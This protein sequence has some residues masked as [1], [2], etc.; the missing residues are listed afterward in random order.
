VLEVGCQP[1]SANVGIMTYVQ[2]RL[3]SV[4]RDVGKGEEASI[5]ASELAARS[6]NKKK[7]D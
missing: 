2:E 3:E 6:Q 1:V 4:P 5:D 7:K